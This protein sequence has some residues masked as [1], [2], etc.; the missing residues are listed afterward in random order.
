M[1]PAVGFEQEWV[2]MFQNIINKIL[3]EHMTVRVLVTKTTH[4]VITFM[5]L[6][7]KTD[8]FFHIFQKRALF[9]RYS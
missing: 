1:K 2:I 7:P 6:A 9:R 5:P 8:N 3:M 4:I